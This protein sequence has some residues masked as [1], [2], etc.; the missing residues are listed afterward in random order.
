[1]QTVFSD[2]V[3]R[4]F[5]EYFKPLGWKRQGQNYRRV[6]KDGLGRIINFQK[7]SWNSKDEVIFYINYGIYIEVEDNI[8][9]KSFKEYECQ[10]R[11]RARYGGGV[12]K[13]TTETDAESVKDAVINA[14]KEVT[15]FFDIIDSKGMFAGMLL[16]G[17]IS[18][19]TKIP[20]TKA[21]MELAKVIE[22]KIKVEE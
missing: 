2:L 17:E 5:E 15:D 21:S 14:L 9:N 12:Y 19:Y 1:M 22:Q 11:N 10:F 18:K 7:S 20:V 16:S 8:V 3:K 4:I 13:L 6:E